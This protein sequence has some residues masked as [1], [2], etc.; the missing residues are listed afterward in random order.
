[1]VS[2]SEKIENSLI[3][4]YKRNRH[5]WEELPKLTA[6]STAAEILHMLFSIHKLTLSLDVKLQCLEHLCAE[7]PYSEIIMKSMLIVNAAKLDLD[8]GIAPTV[9][10]DNVLTIPEI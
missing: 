10:V 2:L 4:S 1:M 9:S 7:A 5:C 8:K 6:S 3:A